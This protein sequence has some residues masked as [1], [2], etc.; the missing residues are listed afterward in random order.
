MCEEEEGVCASP[1]PLLQEEQ[2]QVD[3][4]SHL[5]HMLLSSLLPKW[6]EH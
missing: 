4:S 6:I 2:Q 3:A 1:I 5:R